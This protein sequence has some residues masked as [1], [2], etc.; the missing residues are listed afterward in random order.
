MKLE[1]HASG[2]G[3]DSLLSRSQGIYVLMRKVQHVAKLVRAGL[4]ECS[5]TFP[6]NVSRASVYNR[7]ATT[8]KIEQFTRNVGQKTRM[9][10]ANDQMSKSS[11]VPRIILDKARVVCDWVI[12]RIRIDWL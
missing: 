11:I 2:P 7:D 5:L 6:Y 12:C 1:Y 8:L 9:T 3:L 10:K 4:Q